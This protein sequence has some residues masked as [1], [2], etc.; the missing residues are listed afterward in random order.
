MPPTIHSHEHLFG[1]ERPFASCHASTLVPLPRG[2]Y[3]AAWFGG[4]R[5]SAGDVR[6][7][8]S[9]REG[10]RWSAPAPVPAPKPEPHWNPVLFAPGDGMVHL[11]FKVGTDIS[12]WESWH[13][14]SI[15]GGLSWS[16]PREIVPGDRGGRGPVKNKPVVL[17]DG[18]WLAGASVEDERWRVFVDRSADGGRTW[19]ATKPMGPEPEACAGQGVIQPTLW[20][21]RPGAV[22]MLMRSTGGRV[23]RSDSDDGGRTWS[24]P[25]PTPL[26]HN[27]SGLDLA[28]LADGSLVLVCNPVE[29]P[30]HLPSRR[31]PL[32]VLRSRDNGETWT[33][34]LDLET[35]EGEYSYPAIVAVGE[36]VAITYTWRRERIAFWEGT[37][38]SGSTAAPSG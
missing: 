24:V 28:R 22:H 20:E 3:L 1:D 12:F 2:A 32:S 15:D 13:T 7:W 36:G 29:C 16:P 21:S 11:F 14:T 19:V 5:E 18:T 34:E 30:Q 10:G 4:S 27:N 38:D 35:A 9:R 26:L 33:R 25:R 17:H 23:F 6:I 31:T 8:T 37:F